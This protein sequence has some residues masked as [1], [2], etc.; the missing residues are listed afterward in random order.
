MPRCSVTMLAALALTTIAAAASADEVQTASTDYA[1]MVQQTLQTR[2]NGQCRDGYAL[3]A[4]TQPGT[5]DV[6]MVPCLRRPYTD[7]HDTTRN[8]SAIRFATRAC[9]FDQET[10]YRNLGA[11]LDYMDRTAERFRKSYRRPGNTADVAD[12]ASTTSA[13]KSSPCR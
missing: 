8:E 9:Q 6:I 11:A 12:T 7:D 5:I 13:P 4:A 2:A 10:T 1:A 3:V